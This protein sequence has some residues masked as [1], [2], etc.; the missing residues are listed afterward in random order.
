MEIF[1]IGFTQRS[2]E[3]FFGALNE[4]R[5][6]RLLDVRLKNSSPLAGFAKRDDL[7]YFLRELCGA[8]YEAEP[9]LAPTEAMLE[10]YRKRRLSW[11][12]YETAYV[13]LLRERAVERQL[14]RASFSTP[15]ALL[16]SERTAE[17]CHRRLAL[18]YLAAAWGEVTVQHL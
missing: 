1:S 7:A 12:E 11:A 4:A 9:R 6:G 2:A 14:D 3:A 13:Q 16:C 8:A 18:E 17:Q 15:T 10:S 5:V